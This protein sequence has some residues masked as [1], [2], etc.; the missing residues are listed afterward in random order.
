MNTVDARPRTAAAL[1]L[2]GCATMVLSE[3][4]ERLSGGFTPTSYAVTIAGFLG[5]G[6]AALV[7]HRGQRP[8]DGA[9]GLVGAVLF[10]AGCLLESLGDVVGFGAPTEEALQA[11]TGLLIPIGGVLLVLGGLALG[12]AIVRARR[13]PRWT[14]VV[15]AATPL[16]LP[17]TS[18]GLPVPV[19]S[20]TNSLLALALGVAAWQQLRPAS[21]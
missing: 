15:V 12:V 2:A 8:P 13:Y 3:I 18:L 16:F 1:A 10:A 6:W 20:L 7:A 19:L 4:V 11:R 9:L 14:G 17:A 5:L 21:R